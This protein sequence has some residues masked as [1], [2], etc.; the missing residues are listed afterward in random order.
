MFDTVQL[1]L[2]RR[3]Q[4]SLT[5]A[6]ISYL[7]QEYTHDRI[8]DYQ[9]AAWLMTVC[10]HALSPRET[11]TLTRCMT[12]SGEQVQWKT[13]MDSYSS[14]ND[15]SYSYY[16]IDKHSTGGVGDKAS[17]VLAPLVASMGFSHPYN[18]RVPMMAGRGLGHTGGTIDKL[19]AI[20][21]YRTN[22]TLQEFQHIVNTVGC[23]ITAATPELCPA[24]RKLYALRD[25]TGTVSSISLQ[26]A[27][28][29][30]KKIAERPHSLLLDCKYGKGA[31]QSDQQSAEELAQ[32]MVATGER[33]GLLPTVALL[34]RMDDPLGCAIGNWLETLECIY[35]MQGKFEKRVDLV[36]LIVLQAAYMLQQ[37][38]KFSDDDNNNHHND[39]SIEELACLAVEHL[40]SGKALAKFRE[41]VIAHG[42]DPSVVDAPETYPNKALY[43]ASLLA[44]QDGYLASLDALVFGRSTVHLGAGRLVANETV[45]PTAG[46]WLHV[47]VGDF[48][49]EGDVLATLYTNRPNNVLEAELRSLQSAV[50]YSSNEPV[51]TLPV[52]S[53]KVTSQGTEA[54]PVFLKLEALLNK[55]TSDGDSI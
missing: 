41:L 34:T 21:G 13:T 11:A 39:T 4:E 28:I 23:S 12:E 53:H 24:D 17:L 52:V 46:I 32:S 1:I 36:T 27:S 14:E 45:D 3:R 30:S 38:N 54:V 37:T 10:Y 22:L 9:M 43:T 29:M 31:F 19:E 5:D 49:K 15:P 55:H 35:I 48:V 50:E 16:Y 18:I 51:S 47:A 40:V 20:D 42:G 33:N 2:K 8:P 26:T 44:T 6:E 25:V 7:I